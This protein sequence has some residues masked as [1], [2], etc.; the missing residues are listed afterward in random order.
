MVWASCGLC[1]AGCNSAAEI[2]DVLPDLG[3]GCPR[4]ARQPA[5]SQPHGEGNH[6]AACRQRGSARPPYLCQEMPN[7]ILP[8]NSQTF[9]TIGEPITGPAG[10]QGAAVHGSASV[11]NVEIHQCGQR[12]RHRFTPSMLLGGA[13]TGGRWHGD[14]WRRIQGNRPIGVGGLAPQYC[15]RTALRARRR[16]AAGSRPSCAMASDCRRV[17][18]QPSA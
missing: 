10:F 9:E 14:C 7:S 1:W 8:R 16:N 12:W 13:P 6:C 3:S 2:P 11:L 15:A 18:G 4:S 5:G 17:I